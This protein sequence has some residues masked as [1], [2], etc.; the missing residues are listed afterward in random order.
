M[1]VYS[2]DFLHENSLMH[3]LDGVLHLFDSFNFGHCFP[4]S[5]GSF[6]TIL[7]RRFLPYLQDFLLERRAQ[8][9]QEVHALTAQST[10]QKWYEL[11]SEKVTWPINVSKHNDGLAQ[12]SRHNE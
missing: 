1:D 7:V 11:T 12:F 5:E 4:F 8:G 2:T 3:L 6:T 10:E 9:V